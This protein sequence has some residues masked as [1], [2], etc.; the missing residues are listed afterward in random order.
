MDKTKFCNREQGCQIGGNTIMANNANR[1]DTPYQSPYVH[2]FKP[3]T[4]Q[5]TVQQTTQPTVQQ[6]TGISDD[7]RSSDKTIKNANNVLLVSTEPSR[8][9][10]SYGQRGLNFTNNARQMVETNNPRQTFDIELMF[11]N[12]ERV[13]V[14]SVNVNSNPPL[15]EKTAADYKKERRM[16]VDANTPTAPSQQSG[17]T[18]MQLIMA[19]TKLQAMGVTYSLISQYFNSALNVSASNGM[20]AA[21][22]LQ[23]VLV[24]DQDTLANSTQCYTSALAAVNKTQTTDYS[25]IADV[26]NGLV[27]IVKAFK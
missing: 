6:F 21:L 14:E 17:L 15:H 5:P 16:M 22:F 2:G 13:M 8:T 24:F 26:V 23:S 4:T 18:K 20:S 12:A 1:P 3:Q 25:S 9:K 7:T 27:G 11:K 10:A 19:L